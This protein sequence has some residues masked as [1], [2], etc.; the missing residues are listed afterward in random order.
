MKLLF[1]LIFIKASNTNTFFI[2]KR[3]GLSQ[4]LSKALLS[5][6]PKCHLVPQKKYSRFS[7][8]KFAYLSPYFRKEV[9]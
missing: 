5:L 8:E 3:L 4:H 9:C 2:S 7:E 6:A 1:V